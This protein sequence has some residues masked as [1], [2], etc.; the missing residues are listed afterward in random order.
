MTEIQPDAT[1]AGGE[2]IR[3]D[4]IVVGAGIAGM[5]S[6]Y[7]FREL[8]L[9]VRVFEKGG[10]VGGT[11]YWNRYPGARC[12]VESWDYSY[13]FSPELDQEWEWTERY[14]TQPELERYFNHVADRFDLRKDIQFDTR[15]DA[16]HYD[17]ETNLWRLRTSDGGSSS[18]RYLMMASG[19]I[20]ELNQPSFEGQHTFAGEAHHTARWPK[21]GVDFRGKRVGVIGTGSTAV[22]AIP[23]IAKDAEHLYVFQRTAQYA[24]PAQNH[25]LDPEVAQELKK[26]YPERRALAR[27]TSNGLARIPANRSALEVDEET[28]QEAFEESWQRG[29]AGYTT[30]FNDTLVSEEANAYA[31]DFARE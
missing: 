5:Y 29:G 4:A 31:A 3:Y 22:Q 19:G 9:S 18:A 25:P 8:G 21:E 2:S 17:D 14:P 16:A 10:G 20:S 1:V 15:V 24:V 13:S 23:Q 6:L 28:R 11:W 30:T 26:Q 27:T 7:R 12:D